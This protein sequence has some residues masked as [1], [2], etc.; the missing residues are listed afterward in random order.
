MK[1][2]RGLVPPKGYQRSRGLDETRF[3]SLG[4][5]P[6]KPVKWEFSWDGGMLKTGFVKGP[7]P[8]Q[9]GQPP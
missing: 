8:P 5:D 4:H 1:Q 9:R 3:F 6:A 2:D 7:D